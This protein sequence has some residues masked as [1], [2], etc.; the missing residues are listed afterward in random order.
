M[1]LNI[2]SYRN[3]RIQN[4]LDTCI[5]SVPVPFHH[6]N[7]HHWLLTEHLLDLELYNQ[8]V[9]SLWE[10]YTWREHSYHPF[11]EK[12]NT[13]HVPKLPRDQD[14]DWRLGLADPLLSFLT[15]ACYPHFSCFCP[16]NLI[17]L[18]HSNK[19]EKSKT[20]SSLYGQKPLYHEKVNPCR[21]ILPKKTNDRCSLYCNLPCPD[22]IW[23]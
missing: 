3:L 18:H 9:Q 22:I 5:L 20:D 15:K 12:P 17:N 7:K 13:D 11:R 14:S 10:P 2:T 21:K 23:K 19:S 8:Y 6:R 4:N 16:S 1:W